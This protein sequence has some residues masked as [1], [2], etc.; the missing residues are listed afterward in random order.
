MVADTIGRVSARPGELQV[1]I[2]M[3]VVGAPVL[4]ALTRRR[5]LVA[6]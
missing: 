2:V 3:A 4:L 6:L 5:R 1:G